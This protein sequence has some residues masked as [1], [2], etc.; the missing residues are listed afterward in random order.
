[1][2]LLKKQQRGM[3]ILVI[4]TSL[5]LISMLF[6]LFATQYSILQQKIAANAYRNQQAFEAAQAGLEAALPYFQKNY[7]AII[8]GQSGGYLTPYINSNTQNVTL[9]NGSQYS[10]VLS[11]PNKNNYQLIQI[12]STGTT[13]D[14]S[15]IRV[16]KQLIQA[17]GS[18]M[19]PPTVS[20]QTQGSVS[21]GNTAAINNTQTNVNIN[22]G[23]SIQL[24]NRGHTTT[25]IGL[26]SSTS[27]LGSDVSQN[28]QALS[29]LTPDNFFMSVFGVSQSSLKSTAKYTYNK[30]T[31]YTYNNVLNGITGGIIWVDQ[32]GGTATINSTTIIGSVAKPVILVINGNLVL[33]GSAVINGFV[34]ILNPTTS[35]SIR[36]NAIINGAISSTGNLNFSGASALNYNASILNAL[37]AVSTNYNYAK[38]PASW[39]DF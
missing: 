19:T 7:S 22:A 4:T 38:V 17:Y 33:S 35:V 37:P 2:G 12:T 3:T 28:N 6:I 16:L 1:M 31:D 10:F 9:A 8:A 39:R 20:L 18:G 29:S 15:S 21:L 5:M 25:S 27:G 23:G 36:R 30:V 26:S 34:F 14:G 13:S 32:L 24:S 11:N